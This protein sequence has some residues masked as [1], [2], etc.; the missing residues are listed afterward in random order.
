[1]PLGAVAVH[2][3][4]ASLVQVL[5]P[6]AAALVSAALARSLLRRRRL[7]WSAALAVYALA[8][9][10]MCWGAADGW[11]GR[12]FRIYYLA[13][14]LLTAPL[15]G[16]GSLLLAGRRWATPLGLVYA[17]FACGLA[18]AMPIHGRYGAGIPAAQGHLGTLP[19]AVAIVAN[20]LGTLAVVGVALATVRARPLR[21][22]F[23]LAGVGVA[24]AGSGL[25]GLGVGGVGGFVLLAA[26]LLYLGVEGPPS[27]LRA[28]SASVRRRARS[29]RE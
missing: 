15:F 6:F 12:T 18:L 1:M 9:A 4:Q 2:I 7:A 10:A 21:N 26:C 14:G 27:W 8:A 5:P 17:G 22:A 23:I 29:G 19:R 20:S 11:D 3:V 16:V 25:A 24:A 13:G 28:P